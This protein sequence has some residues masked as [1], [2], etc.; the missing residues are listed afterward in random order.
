MSFNDSNLSVCK[1]PTSTVSLQPPSGRKIWGSFPCCLHHPPNPTNISH[2]RAQLVLVWEHTHQST[3][4][5]DQYK[6]W[7]IGGHLGKFELFEPDNEPSSTRLENDSE[8]EAWQWRCSVKMFKRWTL[9]RSREKTWKHERK[10]MKALV[11][12]LSFNRCMLKTFLGRCDRAFNFPF[13]CSVKS[14]HVKSQL[15]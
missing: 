11:S 15:I 3:Q 9:R 12:R 13:C 10:T 7:K 5:A 1:L 4:Q 8:D 6:G 2:L 14:S